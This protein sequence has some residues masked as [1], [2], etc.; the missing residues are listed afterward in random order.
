MRTMV[1][2]AVG[3]QCVAPAATLCVYVWDL[4]PESRNLLLFAVESRNYAIFCH[5]FDTI[6]I[7]KTV[8]ETSPLVG[9]TPRGC[10]PLVHGLLLYLQPYLCVNFV[11]IVVSGS[12]LLLITVD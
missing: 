2:R 10:R 4:G 9:S 3:E 12:H 1:R 7:V 11:S 5:F 8:F 6:C